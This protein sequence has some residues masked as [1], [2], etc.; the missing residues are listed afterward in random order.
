MNKDYLYVVLWDGWM[1]NF[2]TDSY[3]YARELANERIFPSM[4]IIKRVYLKNQYKLDKVF[5]VVDNMNDFR[6][7]FSNEKDA[8]DM[9]N[10][11]DVSPHKVI[12]TEIKRSLNIKREK[13]VMCTI[14]DAIKYK[15][16]R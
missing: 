4:R 16:V 8:Q 10:S 6:K 5:V 2:V 7:L 14:G 12:R 13:E 15:V 3:E 9:V 1:F 11:I